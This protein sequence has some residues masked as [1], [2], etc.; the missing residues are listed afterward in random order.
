MNQFVLDDL[1][2]FRQHLCVYHGTV[3]AV[4][5]LPSPRGQLG[6]EYVS[7]GVDTCLRLLEMILV[8]CQ[9][10][11]VKRA[12]LS[13]AWDHARVLLHAFPVAQSPGGGCRHARHILPCVV[14]NVRPFPTRNLVKFA[15]L[16]ERFQASHFAQSELD[17]LR[18]LLQLPLV[19]LQ[20]VLPIVQFL[21]PTLFHLYPFH[22]DI[23]TMIL[24][25]IAQNA[26]RCFRLLQFV[27]DTNKRFESLGLQSVVKLLLLVV[28]SFGIGS[29]F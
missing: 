14:T 28:E 22:F 19:S 20:G 3:G 25:G 23:L 15:P 21:V 11:S 17:I 5:A 6:I 1:F 8:E 9:H 2:Q 29:G 4:V 27:V 10:C 12:I 26:V 24:H 18:V 16:T 7:R 13:L